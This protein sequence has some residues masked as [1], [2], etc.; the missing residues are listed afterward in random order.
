MEIPMV[1]IAR[2]WCLF[3]LHNSSFS[4]N[5]YNNPDLYVLCMSHRL[6]FINGH[7]VSLT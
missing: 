7:D 3:L 6:K 1:L 5:Y 4:H 2:V